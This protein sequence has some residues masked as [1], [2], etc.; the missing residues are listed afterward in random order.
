MP[1]SSLSADAAIYYHPPLSVVSNIQNS[2]HHPRPA[3]AFVTPYYLYPYSVSAATTNF[4]SATLS[5][6][7][8]TSFSQPSNWM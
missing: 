1:A 3:S 2:I 7:W 5:A 4:W 6:I 8:P